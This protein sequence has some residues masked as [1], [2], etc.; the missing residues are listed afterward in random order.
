M[1]AVER[2][3]RQIVRLGCVAILDETGMACGAPAEIAHCH[4]GSI[5]LRM[6][7]PKAK[8]RKIGRYYWLV[9]PLCH[10]HGRE[11]YPEGL[12]TEVA[13]ENWTAR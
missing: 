4:N 12:D 10:R 3:W 6:Q 9:L 11:P 13:P 8:G 5:R 7:E 2:H 1:K